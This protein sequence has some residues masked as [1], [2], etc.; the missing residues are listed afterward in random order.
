MLNM[1][2][3]RQGYIDLL[4]HEAICQKPYKD[5]QGYWTV[6]V[7]HAETSGRA[8][9][10]RN[11]PKGV[12]LSFAEVFRI[13]QVVDLPAYVAD[14]N[15][16]LKVAVPQHAFD[17]LVL[18]HINT[19]AISRKGA[20]QPGFLKLINQGV[21]VSDARVRAAFLQ[22]RKPPEILKRRTAEANLLQRGVYSNVAGIVGHYDVTAGGSVIWKSRRN[23]HIAELE[24]Q[25]PVAAANLQEDGDDTNVTAASSM[26]DPNSGVVADLLP[27]D[28]TQ[29]VAVTAELNI[30]AMTKDEIKAFQELLYS[31]GYTT[32]GI[33][34]GEYGNSTR[35][36]MFDFLQEN[37]TPTVPIVLDHAFV[38]RVRQGNNKS[39]SQDRLNPS[40]EVIAQRAPN[41]N[42]GWWVTVVGGFWTIVYAIGNFFKGT[43]E[44]FMELWREWSPLLGGYQQ[45]VLVIGGFVALAGFTYLGYRMQKDDKNAIRKGIIR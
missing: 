14:V 16:A 45:E 39:A 31:K 23:L 2:L 32:V 17:A 36:A 38:E 33:A 6:G 13:L 9:N 25:A 4:G 19:G 41:A 37:N 12:P 44:A 10:P 28:A 43:F 30:T 8:P 21:P 42:K 34:N 22:W 5:S 7:G 15:R 40:A 3:S 27:V 29:N 24:A 20:K 18:F 35:A 11:L 26:G 1:Q